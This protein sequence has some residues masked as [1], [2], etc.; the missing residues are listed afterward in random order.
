MKKLLQ[1][2]IQKKKKVSIGRRKT[3]YSI[4]NAVSR[5]LTSDRTFTDILKLYNLV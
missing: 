2:K 1:D 4:E 5:T 3:N